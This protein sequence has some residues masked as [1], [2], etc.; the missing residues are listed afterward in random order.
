MGDHTLAADPL[1]RFEAEHADALVVLN[2]LE[3]A[4]QKLEAGDPP[5]AQ[6]AIVREVHRF[7]TTA[8]RQHNED[9][10]AALFPLLDAEL[11]IALF[12]ME[13]STLR[14]LEHQL[15]DA[16]RSA[17]PVERV[18]PVADA[19]SHLLRAHIDRENHVLFPMVR[20]RL[21][22]SGLAKVA[23]RLAQR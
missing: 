21:G 20:E 7:L 8:V 15:N 23:A 3:Q 2:R 10:E 4:C 13:H 19:L 17:N 5:A 6:L 18:P 22:S 9:E 12:E 1:L 16:L 11:P 14:S